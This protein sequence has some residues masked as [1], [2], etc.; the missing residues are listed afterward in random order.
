MNMND[1]SPLTQRQIELIH[2]WNAIVQRY[3]EHRNVA[4]LNADIDAFSDSGKVAE[5]PDHW[6]VRVAETVEQYAPL[7]QAERRRKGA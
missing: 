2:E 1:S 3:G 7:F 5:L 6:Q 4:R